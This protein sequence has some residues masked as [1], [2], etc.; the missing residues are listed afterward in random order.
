MSL[1]NIS[2]GEKD[3]KKEPT[4]YYSKKQENAVAK[5][6]NG[7]RTL[8][9]GATKFDRGDVRLD[10][11]LIECKTRMTPSESISIR[12]EWIEKNDS[13][14]LFMGKKHSALAFNFGPDM[15]NYYIIDEY[16]FELLVEML[17]YE[18]DK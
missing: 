5:K 12:K 6:F 15:K 2:H 10:K 3:G 18:E 4:R 9:S 1:L 11:F 17:E 7:T 8:N 13:E 16:L 14:A